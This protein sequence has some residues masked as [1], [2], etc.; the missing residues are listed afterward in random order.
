MPRYTRNQ[1]ILAKIETTY[2]VD[3]V[4][5]PGTDALLT[6]NLKVKAL[7]GKTVS[8][9]LLYPYFGASQDLPVY[10]YVSGSFDVGIAGSGAAGTAPPWGKLLRAAG[11]AE[12]VT[13]GNRVDYTPISTGFESLTIYYYDDGLLKKALGCR[14]S[15]KLNL[16]YG[17]IPTLSCT[18]MGLD[19]GEAVLANPATTLTAWKTPLPVNQ[20]NSGQIVLGGSYAA[21]ALSGGT[22]SVTGGLEIDLGAKVVFTELIGGEAIDIVDRSASGKINLD[23]SAALEVSTISS[24]RSASTQSIGM[25][26][27]T[28]AGGK[29]LVFAPNCQLKSPER[30]DQNGRRLVGCEFMAIPSSGNDELRIVAL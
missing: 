26:H 28:T 2:G 3:A 29:I 18:F 17:A 5:V 23:L 10:F 13:A 9:D 4:P 15:F 24:I 19:G 11:L 20:A 12:V 8:R 27:G 30:S 14:M 25:V 21:G 22:A 7:D 6:S 16:N 1:A